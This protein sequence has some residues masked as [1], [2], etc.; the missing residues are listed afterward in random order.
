MFETLPPQEPDKII[1]LMQQ[2]R[3]DP[4]EEKIDLGVG[5][6]K[7]AD[8]ITPVMRAVK[9]AEQRVWEE[10][11]TKAYTGLI[12]D[13]SFMEAMTSLVLGDAV[14]NS[15]V[16][17]A[18][19]PGGTGAIRIGLEMIKMAGQDRRVFISDP[20]WPNH[21]SIIDYVGLER[22]SY[23]YFDNATRAVDFSG[24]MEDLQAL[25]AGDVLLLHGCCHNPTGANLNPV[26]W[27][28]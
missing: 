27:Y 1:A 2:F 16:A 26:E 7:N 9:A 8:G 23:R 13:P 15:S 4:R 22:V 25:K 14:P 18:G 3:D 6:Y 19:T 11:T 12:G 20:T 28:R 10:Q 5:V 24:M 21:P 17:W